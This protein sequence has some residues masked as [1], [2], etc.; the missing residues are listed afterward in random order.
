MLCYLCSYTNLPVTRYANLY[1]KTQ[2]STEDPEMA[3][4]MQCSCSL[5]ALW[6]T[7]SCN[8]SQA[9]VKM[10]TPDTVAAYACRN[11]GT[12]SFAFWQIEGE[13][14]RSIGSTY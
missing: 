4:Y 9:T 1:V 6:L 12:V 7:A 3:D 8:T 13:P 2:P 10:F 14:P 11:F 5:A